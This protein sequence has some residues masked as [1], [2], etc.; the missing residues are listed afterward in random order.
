[1]NAIEIRGLRKRWGRQEVVRDVSLTVEAGQV[2]GLVGPNGSGKTTTLSCALGLLQPSAG[3][4][5]VLGVPSQR[6]H[7]TAGRVGVVFDTPTLVESLDCRGNL[8]YAR[9]TL[10]HEG[11]RALDEALEL[12]GLAQLA[13]RRASKLSLGQKRRLAIA[14]ALLGSPELLVLD[15]P[16]SGLDTVGVRAMLRLFERLAA[17]GM[18]L[19]LS[20]HRLHEME[21]VVSHVGILLDGRLVAGGALDEVLGTDR[22]ACRVVVRPHERALDVLRA[23]GLEVDAQDGSGGPD[24]LRVFLDGTPAAELNRRLVEAGCEVSALVPAGRS[25]Q[26]VFE[27]LIDARDAARPEVAP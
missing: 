4:C 13:G 14:R 6:L 25:L 5:A 22:D 21:R 2:Y 16:L 24:E 8:T 26:Q 9:R 18:T 1:M 23:S 12:V 3:T 17:E 27:D 7:R 19:L 11:G 15:E 20:S 10:G